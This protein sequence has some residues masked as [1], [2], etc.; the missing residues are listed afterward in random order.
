M[1]LYNKATTVKTCCHRCSFDGFSFLAWLIFLLFSVMWYCL[2][3][4]SFIH[5]SLID[6]LIESFIHSFIHCCSRLLM[7]LINGS[8]TRWCTRAARSR[9]QTWRSSWW[10]AGVLSTTCSTSSV[11][12]CGWAR[13]AWPGSGYRPTPA[14]RW[15]SAS[16][17]CWPSPSSCCSSPRARPPPP[18]L[19]R[20]SVSSL[21]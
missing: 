2:I 10:C 12:V 7:L 1:V 5:F 17:S 9:T 8:A 13:S 15:R 21:R 18:S 6:W 16:P 3:K 14:R 19:C 4:N 11:L 20:L